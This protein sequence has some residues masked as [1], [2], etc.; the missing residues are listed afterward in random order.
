MSSFSGVVI[1]LYCVVDLFVLIY[2][3]LKGLTSSWL[4]LVGAQNPHTRH[5]LKNDS[6]GWT[7]DRANSSIQNI[8][9][10]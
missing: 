5:N 7:H 8:T 2:A 1:F 4:A 3:F 6:N 10:N 9:Q